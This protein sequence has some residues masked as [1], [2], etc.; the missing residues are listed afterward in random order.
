MVIR[1]LDVVSI[2]VT[3]HEADA[4]LVVDSDTVLSRPL[5][6]ELFESVGRWDA[7]GIQLSNGLDHCELTRSDALNV[8]GDSSDKPS[9]ENSLGLAVTK[10][11]NHNN[12]NTNAA[13]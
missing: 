4:P 11:L 10:G 12:E 7:Q 2:A 8:L 6:F 13:R 1:N 3:P 9:V 5:A